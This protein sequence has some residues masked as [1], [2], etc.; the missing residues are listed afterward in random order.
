MLKVHNDMPGREVFARITHQK[1]I[2]QQYGGIRSPVPDTTVDLTI[3]A[4][5]TVD[6][7]IGIA[8]DKVGELH[9]QF[10]YVSFTG[11]VD[12]DY[13]TFKCDKLRFPSNTN[14]IGNPPERI[15]VTKTAHNDQDTRS[16]I[17]I[18]VR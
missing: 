14:A 8:D 18:H 17:H 16:E 15:D 9:L 13:G 12:L 11:P 1:D 5:T 6:W 4:G 2:S 3:L 7:L 10:G